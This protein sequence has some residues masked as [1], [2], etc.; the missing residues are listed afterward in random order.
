MKK[1]ELGKKISEWRK[2]KGMTQEELVEKCNLNVRTIQRIEAG[3]V[4]PRSYTI[5]ALMEALEI[6]ETDFLKVEKMEV[7]LSEG[8][9]NWIIISFIAGVIYF[10]LGFIEIPMDIKMMAGMGDSES[11]WGVYP[12]LKIIVLISS[13]LFFL[14][15]LKIAKS[16]KDQLL[17]TSFLTLVIGNI[18]WILMDIFLLNMGSFSQPLYAILKLGSLGLIYVFVGFALFKFETYEKTFF[19]ALGIMGMITGILFS[20]VVGAAGG[21]LAMT[22]FEIALLVSLVMYFK[23]KEKIPLSSF[24]H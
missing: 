4:M 6:Q 9:K 23:G 24:A 21:L 8:L 17:K 22:I 18:F 3:E 12:T 16:E 11:R 2:A 10:I 14:G 13:S 7:G 15:F 5:K 1:P 19:G 20:S